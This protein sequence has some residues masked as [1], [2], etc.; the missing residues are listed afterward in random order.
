MISIHQLY[1]L[2]LAHPRIAT[3]TRKIQPGDLFF[4]LHGE[5]FDGNDFAATALDKGACHAVIDKPAL[6]G[7]PGTLLVDDV[8]QSLQQLALYHRQQFRIPFIGIT[9]TNGKTTTKEL[10]SAVLAKKFI[11]AATQGNLNNHIGVPLTLLSVNEETEIAVI[12][13][14]ANH[15][16]EIED[17]CRL[18]LPDAGLITNIG[19]AHL[20]GF[21]NLDNIITTKTALY[22][23][24][25]QKKGTIFVNAGDTVLLEKS[26][27]SE[28]IFYGDGPNSQVHGQIVA[29]D[30]FLR[31]C[32][33]EQKIEIGTQVAGAWNLDNLVAAISVG[34]YYG[35][36]A[37][38]IKAALESYQPT[39][40]RSQIKASAHNTILLD[41]Y[42]ANPTSMR[43][44]IQHF[45][46]TQHTDKVL[47][48]GDM[49]ELGSSSDEEHESLLELVR[50]GGFKQ[51][52]LIGSCFLK[53][54]N[55][56]AYKRFI[57]TESALSW[58]SSAGL[59]GKNIL[60]KGSRGIGLERIVEYL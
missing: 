25:A 31:M 43:A 1:Q 60:I 23:S 35:V 20:E 8:L 29:T 47:I 19:K 38:D 51:V 16:G 2:F 56:K 33:K 58:F 44:A 11:V 54:A 41:T 55:G 53:T 6:A 27:G 4:C 12:E 34:Q 24:V 46:G 13:M 40:M 52:Y 59:K 26:S 37:N 28:R 18:S 22:R 10:L 30:P 45:A 49:L 14:G 32:W 50:Q 48:L 17:L 42:N 5:N 57:D 39:N 7:L 36:A 3:D 15:P 21:I 9:G